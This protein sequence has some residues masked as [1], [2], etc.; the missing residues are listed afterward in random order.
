VTGAL[1]LNTMCEWASQPHSHEG[2]SIETPMVPVLW[3]ERTRWVC[4]VPLEPFM[5]VF[6]YGTLNTH[7]GLQFSFKIDCDRLQDTDISCFVR[8]I[9]HKF[10]FS[11][12]VGVPRGGLRLAE[13]LRPHCVPGY[14]VMVVDDVMTTGASM[15]E[16][17]AAV[18]AEEPGASVNGV[19][20]FSRGR[21]LPWV[22]PILRV[23]D[24][25]QARGTGIG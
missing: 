14:P 2:W 5:G 4:R 8:I 17:R 20:M 23:A 13:A 10:I 15:E 7:S 6:K 21:E 16:A 3:P 12:V 24:W 11:R 22:W 18:L 19:V 25:A 1:C 9:T